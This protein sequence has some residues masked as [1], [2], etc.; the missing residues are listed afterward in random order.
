MYST[1]LS[2]TNIVV[3]VAGAVTTLAAGYYAYSTYVCQEKAAG[4]GAPGAPTS[5][6]GAPDPSTAAADDE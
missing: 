1:S 5:D 3:L 6:G 2:R 4:D